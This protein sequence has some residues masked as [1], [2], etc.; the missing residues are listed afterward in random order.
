MSSKAVPLAEY[1][2][3]KDV[4]ASSRRLGRVVGNPVQTKSA[5]C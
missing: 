2:L 3:Q 1:T 5:Y 4:L